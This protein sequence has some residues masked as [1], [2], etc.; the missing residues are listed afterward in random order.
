MDV[1][2]TLPDFLLHAVNVVYAVVIAISFEISGSVVIPIEN[3]HLH[4][5]NAGIVLLSYFIIVSSWIGYFLSTKIEPHRGV[6]G[7]AR[8]GID[9]FIIFLFYYIVSL[10][11][12]RN[13]QF[14]H[15]IFLYILPILY[16]TYLVWDV[17]KHIEYQRSNFTIEEKQKRARWI[18]ITIDY[19]VVFI[20]VS[21]FY[22]IST[23]YVPNTGD[24][25][26][27]EWLFIAASIVF[28]AMF[29][30]AKWKEMH[31]ARARRVRRRRDNSNAI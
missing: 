23:I 8:F 27:R 13:E 22:Y 20:F 9:L 28:T 24:T 16:A 12:P 1:P 10:A 14:Q 26:L 17:I 25:S 3:I 5:V 31:T 21:L 30:R 15:D 4:A 7:I 6:L 11:Q 19:L 2:K 29:R 18:A